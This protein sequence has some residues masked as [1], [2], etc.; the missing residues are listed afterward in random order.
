MILILF[1]AVV[2]FVWWNSMSQ[3]V[4]TVSPSASATPSPSPT[5]TTPVT[6]PPGGLKLPAPVRAPVPSTNQGTVTFAIRDKAEALGNFNYI[7]LQLSGLSVHKSGGGWTN[8][9]STPP[10]LDLLKI[11]LTEQEAAFLTEMNLDAG[12]YDQIRLEV[13]NLVLVTK[14]GMY[15]DTKLPSKQLKLNTHLVVEKGNLSSA[16]VDI[17][18]GKSIHLTGKGLY[19]FSPVVNVETRSKLSQVQVFPTGFVTLIGGKTDTSF[20]AGMDETGAMKKDFM[21]DSTTDL[22]VVGD[23]I[24][25]I[26]KE[27]SEAKNIKITP[28]EA[29]DTAIKSG[30]ITSALSIKLGHW[31]NKLVWQVTG[32]K[33][34]GTGIVYVDVLTGLVAGTQ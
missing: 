2:G 5:N 13:G 23:A 10:L 20:D 34:E 29:L 30:S 8:M 16:T 19:I 31:A 18:S 26:P 15:H 9:K 24:H 25:I 33:G 28:Q 3:P 22:D 17:I 12:I 14:D 6:V 27:E 1:V 11:S 32:V 7:L 4:A 21:F